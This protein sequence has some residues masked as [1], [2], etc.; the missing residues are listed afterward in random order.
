MN[1]QANR[2]KAIKQLYSTQLN[3]NK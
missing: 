3:V 1:K 2:V